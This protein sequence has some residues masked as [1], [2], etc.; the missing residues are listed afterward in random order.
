MDKPSFQWKQG[1]LRVA[2][3]RQIHKKHVGDWLTA[4]A[5]PFRLLLNGN[6][7]WLPSKAIERSPVDRHNGQ[8]RQTFTSSEFQEELPDIFF[9]STVLFSFYAFEYVIECSYGK[10]IFSRGFAWSRRHCSELMNQMSA[11]V[12]KWQLITCFNSQSLVKLF[13]WCC[14]TIISNW[15]WL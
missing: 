4:G 7:Q 2:N 14:C 1:A 9:V 5:S 15:N 8:S 6:F 12:D 11:N 10:L 13:Q 3:R